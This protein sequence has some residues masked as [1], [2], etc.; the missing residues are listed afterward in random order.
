MRASV[1]GCECCVRLEFGQE[2]TF[3]AAPLSPPLFARLVF[4]ASEQQTP[5][6]WDISDG[7]TRRQSGRAG[8]EAFPRDSKSPTKMP[9]RRMGSVCIGFRLPSAAAAAAARTQTDSCW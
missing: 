7:K 5:A 6:N 4:I 8:E 3:P 2:P 1:D 9:A